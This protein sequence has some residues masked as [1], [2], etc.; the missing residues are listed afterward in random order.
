MKTIGQTGRPLDA[1]DLAILER[2]LQ[3]RLPP[4]YREF[5][6]TTNGGTPSSSI[7]DVSSLPGS[8]TD[9]Q[10]FFGV[11]RSVES[12]NLRWNR[13]MFAGR[14]PAELLPIA[15]DSGGNLFAVCSSIIPR[16]R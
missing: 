7:V 1:D 10:V 6:L 13:K 11:D 2:E 4:K 5:L 16:P 14:I 12:S 15:C 9:L 3:V 8:P